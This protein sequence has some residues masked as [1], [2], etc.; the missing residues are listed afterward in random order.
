MEGYRAY[1]ETEQ[2]GRIAVPLC[3]E[4]LPD[5]ADIQGHISDDRHYGEQGVEQPSCHRCDE[6]L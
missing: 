2:Y 5:D 6:D 1:V 3:D 4:C